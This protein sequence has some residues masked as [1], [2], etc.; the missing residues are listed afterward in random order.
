MALTATRT[1]RA[2]TVLGTLAA[3]MLLLPASG[4]GARFGAKLVAANGTTVLEPSNSVPAHDCGNAAQSCTRVSVKSGTGSPGG[5][6]SSPISGTLKRIRLVAGAQ[7]SFRFQ[8]ARAQN[9]TGNHGDAKI[10]RRYGTLINYQGNGFDANNQIE[11]F[12][13]GIHV[14]Q[15]DYL[16]IKAKKTSALRCNSGGTRQLLFQP[17]LALGGGFQTS[18]DNDSC[19]LMI[20]AIVRA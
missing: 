5:N 10:V 17:A 1:R 16:A 13:I 7:G 4:F 11:V 15:G 6:I 20:Q 12:H 2:A 9:I 19:T 8:L 14:N 3:A 18:T